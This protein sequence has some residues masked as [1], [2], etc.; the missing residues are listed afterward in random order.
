MK[1]LF[2]A[3]LIILVAISVCGGAR[4][5]RTGKN[6]SPSN[7]GNAVQD[8]IIFAV[9]PTADFTISGSVNGRAP[10][11]ITFTD[12]S[13][14]VVDSWL[15]DFGD[16]T[17]S[18]S[19]NPIHTFTTGAAANVSLTVTNGAGS[20]SKTT[21]GAVDLLDPYW[22]PT[23]FTRSMMTGKYRVLSF[24]MSPVSG[25]TIN[26]R[27]YNAETGVQIGTDS[28]SGANPPSPAGWTVADGILVRVEYWVSSAPS[29]YA[30]W[31]SSSS[32]KIL[33]QNDV[34]I[35]GTGAVAGY[36]PVEFP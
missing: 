33:T 16:G 27:A 14:G 4:D 2:A 3:I 26:V 28:S 24:I 5:R 21:A 20:D 19:Q 13:A 34:M 15:W 9:A 11:T 10:Q 30:A 22:V 35:D 32:R 6:S 12:A 17:T 36:T 1:K 29:G 23:T 25:G 31:G 8:V 18:T 7:R